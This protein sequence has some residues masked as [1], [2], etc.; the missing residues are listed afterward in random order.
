MDSMAPVP[1]SDSALRVTAELVRLGYYDLRSGLVATLIATGGLAWVA[2]QSPSPTLVWV[3]LVY[4]LT[5][6]SLRGVGAS[7]YRRQPPKPGRHRPW[8]RQFALGAAFTGLGW[9]FAAWFFYPILRNDELPLLILV[10]AGIT[11]GATRSLGPNL[12][13]C[14]SFQALSLLPLVVRMFQGGTTT[15]TIMG[16][17]ASFYTAFLIAMARSYH[18]SLSNSLRHGFESAALAAELGVKQRQAAALNRELS[19]EI[20]HRRQAESDLRA[21]KERAEGANQAKSDFLATMSH[22][23]RTPMNGIL[24]MLD[25]LNTASLTAAQREQV[26]TAARSADSLLRILNDILDFSKIESGRLD[27]ESIP[28]RPASVGEDI[29][30]LMQPRS[31]A[32]SLELKFSADEKSR[33]RVLGDPMRVRQVLLNL[34][35]NAVKFSEHGDISLDMTGDTATAG[36]LRLTVRV[37]DHGIGMD[38]ETRAHLFEP[39]KQADSSMSRKYG[40]SGLG[41]A[42]SQRLVQGMGGSIT[43]QSNPG[44]G[45]MFEFILSLPV[46]KGRETALPFATNAPWPR[47][48]DARILVVEDDVVNQRVIT[49][50]LQRLGLQCHV[51]ADGQAGLTAIEAGQWDLVLMDCQLPGIDGLETTRRARLMAAGRDLPIVALTANARPEDRAACLA[52]GMDDFITKPVRTETLQTCLTRWL[53]PMP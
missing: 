46:A 43:V 13:A 53:H 52:A 4:M 5:V 42:I 7:L 48:V 35:G 33:T 9:G 49:L 41:L 32:K 25:L 10:V 26:E 29:V 38:E 40:G 17:L 14:W 34:V 31:A 15:Q 16:L 18:L 6:V 1:A 3:W 22:E 36:T 37:R 30:A 28:F 23:I 12:T 21:A 11:A 39:F 24:G 50:M 20:A 27:Y 45:S 8:G 2:V 19:A 51:V 44:E 47:H